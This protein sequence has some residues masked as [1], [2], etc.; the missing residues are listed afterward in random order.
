M[1][2]DTGL[3]AW[4]LYH[5]VLVNRR[6]SVDP[7]RLREKSYGRLAFGFPPRSLISPTLP[8]GLQGRD[9]GIEQ[10]GVSG[11]FQQIDHQRGHS[12]GR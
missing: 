10:V 4:D 1:G 8:P 12:L 5:V 11:K 3:V 9:Y 6:R 7:V 2:Q